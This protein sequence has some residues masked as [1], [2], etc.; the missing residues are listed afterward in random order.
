MQ[1]EKIE[2]LLQRL[3]EQKINVCIESSLTVSEH[4]VDIAIK[5]VDEF[6]IDIKIL[7]EDNVDKINGNVELFLKNI[8]KV[9]ENNCNVIFRIPLVPKYTVTDANMKK[10]LEILNIYKPLKVEIFKIHRLGEKKYKTLGKVMPEFEEIS[11]TK[12]YEIKRKI[13]KL[14]IKVEYCK[15]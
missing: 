7:D 11:D 15:I 8:K 3:K 2:S 6:I 9:F 12:V 13:E 14:G 4:L 10:I 1:F 5:Y